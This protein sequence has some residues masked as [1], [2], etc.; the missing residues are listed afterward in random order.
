MLATAV[1]KIL[2]LTATAT[3]S[4]RVNTF[5]ITTYEGRMSPGNQTCVCVCIYVYIYTC[6]RV[7]ACA[8]VNAPHLMSFGWRFV[9]AL[10]ANVV[11]FAVFSCVGHLQNLAPCKRSQQSRRPTMLSDQAHSCRHAGGACVQECRPESCKWGIDG[12]RR[13]DRPA[14]P[15]HTA[16]R[17]ADKATPCTTR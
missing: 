17:N 3:W 15:M 11:W 9:E 6:V 8:C 13:S 1:L 7:C 4:Y 5:S 12:R 16:R 2:Y 14:S 10:G